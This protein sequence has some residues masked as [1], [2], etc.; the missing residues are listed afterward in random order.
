MCKINGFTQMT[1][2]TSS[3]LTLT[4]ISCDRFVAI[5]FPFRARITK[6]R[7]GVVITVI[8][9]VALA[10]ATPFLVYR[11][12]FQIQWKDFSQAHCDE[13]WPPSM[14]YDESLQKCVTTYPSK[15]LYY[16]FVAVILFFLPVAIM[17]T[18]YFLIIWRLWVSE[19]PGE[20]N[21]VNVE[22]Q[23]RSKK[24]V[25]KLVCIV[26][27]AFVA[28]W[29]PLQV[30]ILYSQF[31]HS[32]TEIGELPEWFSAVSYYANFFAYF[33]SAL[34][35]IIYGGFNSNFRKSFY[36]VV[37]CGYQDSHSHRCQQPI[38]AT[39]QR[40]CFATNW[41]NHFVVH[42][43]ALLGLS[44][45]CADH[46]ECLSLQFKRLSA[47][48]VQYLTH[49]LENQNKCHQGN[50]KKSRATLTSTASSTLSSRKWFEYRKN[51]TS[52][53]KASLDNE[54]KNIESQNLAT[55]SSTVCLSKG[56]NSTGG[57]D[58]LRSEFLKST[59]KNKLE[60]RV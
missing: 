60:N 2:L 28:C 49:C 59:L 58:S 34:N 35:P 9:L 30:I 14:D 45:S 56:G 36:V 6:Q 27:I 15:Q 25:I 55:F 29:L 7:T 19:V 1:C 46:Y 43:L 11:E 18:A 4:A 44:S 20:R 3:V 40:G 38:S 32:S 23:H 17:T 51:Q 13:S 12:Y 37:K 52:R 53:Y 8:W 42:K 54:Q 48:W 39:K 10:V 16:T 5:L 31:V 22:V 26:L 57:N 21:P 47:F 33:N 24:R 50:Y 41:L